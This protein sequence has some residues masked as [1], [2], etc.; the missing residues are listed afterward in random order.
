MKLNEKREP[1]FFPSETDQF[2]TGKNS[3][4]KFFKCN[5]RI[6]QHPEELQVL[7]LQ[8]MPPSQD[9]DLVGAERARTRAEVQQ[10]QEGELSQQLDDRV[11]VSLEAVV[12]DID[13]SVIVAPHESGSSLHRRGAATPG[14]PARL[15]QS[16]GR[17]KVE[18]LI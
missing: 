18:R 8:E 5:K 6:F 10:A 12:A 1:E 15:R 13:D 2:V 11:A 7:P 14:K 16:N 3:K 4:D 17:S 9:A